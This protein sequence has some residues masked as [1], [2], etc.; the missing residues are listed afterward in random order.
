MTDGRAADAF[1]GMPDDASGL[2]KDAGLDQGARILRA[3]W[4][5]ASLASGWR[6]PS[7]WALPEVDT[8]C[9]AIVADGE[10][11]EALA[12]L[13]RARAAA[14][15]G[16]EETLADMAALH[17]VLETAD[18]VG[19]FVAPSIDG[20]PARFVRITAVAWADVAF[21]QIANVEVTDSLTGLPSAPYLRT[22]LGEIYRQAA[23]KERPVAEDHVLL[24]VSIDVAELSGWPRLT[25]MILTADVLRSVFDGGETVASLGPSTLAV[26]AGR[27]TGVSS[28]AVTL[29][30]KLTEQ[31][32]IDPQL[33]D[34]VHPEIRVVR[35]PDD[36]D[37]ANALLSS[38]SH[39]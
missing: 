7:D 24:V 6:F 19:G 11:D 26:L 8:V 27:E 32:L 17:A 14:G 37:S 39:H 2:H 21:D 38:L 23:R 1:S 18:E 35:L 13:G 31:L 20:A 36:I 22:R 4:R 30:R 34:A 10:T 33:R 9:A 3:R 29:R 28:S 25:V 15:A 12:G 16:L 5:S